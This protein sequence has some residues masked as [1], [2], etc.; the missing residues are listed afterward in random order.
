M[1]KQNPLTYIALIGLSIHL[2]LNLLGIFLFHKPAAVFF[3]EQWWS[4]W[5]PLWLV[6]G[7]LTITGIGIRSRSKPAI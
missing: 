5:F 6:W 1:K 7:V 4:S 2:V 3:T